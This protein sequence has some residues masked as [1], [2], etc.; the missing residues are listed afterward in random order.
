M[1]VKNPCFVEFLLTIYHLITMSAPIS[2]AT[3]MSDYL[4][5]SI[6]FTSSFKRFIKFAFFKI[7]C[8]S[9]LFP[10]LLKS[11]SS[12]GSFLKIKIDL[13]YALVYFAAIVTKFPTSS[14]LLSDQFS[15]PL[16]SSI[17]VKRGLSYQDAL[18][19]C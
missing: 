4:M 7:V 15:C 1:K 8:S 18:I 9:S 2:G 13:F 19:F 17:D 16:T 11:R 12:S 3:Y 5:C 6:Y 10:K 14:I